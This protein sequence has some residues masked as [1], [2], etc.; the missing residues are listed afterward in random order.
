MDV[1]ALD[2]AGISEVVAPNGTAVT[3]AQL[4]R[5]WRLDPSP[6]LCFD[7]DSAGQK[8]AYRA[9]IRALP[10]VGPDKTLKIC[11][12]P[13]GKDPDDLIKHDGRPAFDRIL[14]EA[15]NLH[16][17]LWTA[18]LEREPLD[19]PESRAN[20]GRRLRSLAQTIQ[21][22]DVR[23]QYLGLFNGLLNEMYE[24]LRKSRRFEIGS[25]SLQKRNIPPELLAIAKEGMTQ[26]VEIRV[27]LNGLLR[28]P[29]LI[30]EL[31]E[32]IA[33][34]WIK[35]RGWAQI[36]ESMLTAALLNHPLEHD[37]L[38]TTLQQEG[39]AQRLKEMCRSPE[40]PYTFLKE[41]ASKAVAERDLAA[42]IEKVLVVASFEAASADAQ[43]RYAE[44]A[45]ENE[46]AEIV[47]EL[48]R[49]QAARAASGERFRE[50]WADARENESTIETA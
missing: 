33:S 48:E 11:V 29:T 27:I 45:D 40:L 23:T 19:T 3:E 6:I 44:A 10:N 5:M 47:A 4:E 16:Q 28:Y 31:A 46:A 41:E 50:F 26:A 18:E 15:R 22:A 43:R 38:Q 25:S 32:P 24:N 2:R 34:L 42:V 9:A 17:F 7:G 39:L 1:I 35:N 14:S 49:I 36:R 13:P 37:T 21:D 8:A 30:G 12:L 20:L